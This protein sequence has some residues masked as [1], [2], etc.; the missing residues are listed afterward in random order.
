MCPMVS[1][2]ITILESLFDSNFRDRAK[3]LGLRAALAS[4]PFG[5]S[6]LWDSLL[7]MA[8]LLLLLVDDSWGPVSVTAFKKSM[9]A[10]LEREKNS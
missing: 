3:C 9:L 7:M 4:I 2:L 5:G 1:G 6:A 8:S 10:D